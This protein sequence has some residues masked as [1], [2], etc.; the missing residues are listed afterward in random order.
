VERSNAVEWSCGVTGSGGC[1]G[2]RRCAWAE[3]DAVAGNF[4]GPG[5]TSPGMSAPHNFATRIMAAI[6]ALPMEARAEAIHAILS[7][8]LKDRSVE[9]I[10][11]IREEVTQRFDAGIPI[12]RSALDLID[13]QLALREIA[14]A[15]C[16][17]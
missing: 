11:Q 14:G 13:G 5:R 10:L 12:I 1:G 6:A 8:M 16:W 4:G 2:S 3:K 7:E 17:R 15:A 9:S